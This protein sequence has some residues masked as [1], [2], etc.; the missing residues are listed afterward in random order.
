[1]ALLENRYSA[2]AWRALR[3]IYSQPGLEGS[4]AGLER[5]RLEVFK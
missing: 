4:A 2:S 3:H 5:R 1:M